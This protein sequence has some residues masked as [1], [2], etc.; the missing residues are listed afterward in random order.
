MRK[1]DAAREAARLGDPDQI[2]TGYQRA[3]FG[4]DVLVVLTALGQ[5][6]ARQE[7]RK[8]LQALTESRTVAT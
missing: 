8:D 1:E 2:P 7:G 5:A 6:D 3:Y 4:Q